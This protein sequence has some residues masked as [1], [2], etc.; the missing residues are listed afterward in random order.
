MSA[1]NAA[2]IRILIADDHPIL[3]EGICAIIALQTD[4]ELVGEA[5]NGIEAVRLYEEL[6][7]EGVLVD[8]RVPEMTGGAAGGRRTRRAAARPHPGA[9][10]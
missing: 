1:G 2:P 8:L 7:P 10:R 5:A 6:R 4:M 3:R 9:D